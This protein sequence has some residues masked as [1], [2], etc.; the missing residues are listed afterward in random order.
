MRR[1]CNRV[2]R[3]LKRTRASCTIGGAERIQQICLGLGL[4]VR[5]KKSVF[6]KELLEEI[7]YRADLGSISYNEEHQRVISSVS[8]PVKLLIEH[9][10]PTRT[11][12]ETFNRLHKK[13]Y[14]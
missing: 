4:E 3:K 14:Y 13:R 1:E 11:P 7:A 10:L 5:A 9:R 6:S 2:R 12:L 8:H